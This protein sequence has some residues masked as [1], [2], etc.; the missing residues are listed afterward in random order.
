MEAP[1]AE[2][3]AASD[4]RDDFLSY[5]SGSITMEGF[6]DNVRWSENMLV[7]GEV[8]TRNGVDL[9]FVDIGGGDPAI[10]ADSGF[11]RYNMTPSPATGWFVE[12]PCLYHATTPV[13]FMM[14][15][16]PPIAAFGAYI[17]DPADFTIGSSGD[18][19][20]TLQ[21]TGGSTEV[22]VVASVPSDD[23]LLAFFGVIAAAG[24]TYD[25]V[26]IS[27]T[28]AAAGVGNSDR[29]GI[30][31]IYWCTESDVLP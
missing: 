1:P 23:G 5:L 30:D 27:S 10:T 28:I 15:F 4:A 2:P 29:I 21:I 7:D 26:K 11:G 18:V 14:T 13:E 20:V 6:E 19:K 9:T 8:V 12:F 3:N 25:S 22:F 31:N 16:D 17:T 24:V